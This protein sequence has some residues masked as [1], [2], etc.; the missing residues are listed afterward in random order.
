MNATEQHVTMAAQRSGAKVERRV[1]PG[2]TKETE[3]KNERIK[4]WI[5]KYVHSYATHR[6]AKWMN[7]LKH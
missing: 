3:M 1:R 7:D 6:R 5:T 2:I 4:A